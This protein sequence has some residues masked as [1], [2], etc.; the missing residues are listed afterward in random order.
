MRGA[1]E[2]K[3]GGNGAKEHLESLGWSHEITLID[4][5]V[6]RRL[7]KV[8][9]NPATGLEDERTPTEHLVVMRQDERH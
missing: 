5:I 8:E 3:C 4:T 6:S 1:V 9:I 2:A 7:A